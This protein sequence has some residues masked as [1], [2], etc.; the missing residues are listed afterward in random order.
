VIVGE[1]ATPRDDLPILLSGSIN[2]KMPNVEPNG[3]YPYTRDL[4][5][6]KAHRAAMVPP[7]PRDA[8]AIVTPLRSAAW[9]QV[10]CSHPDQA[11]GQ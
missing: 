10:L 6:L 5:Q 4:L 8:T 1:W 9:E 2:V 11:F 7:L 3:S